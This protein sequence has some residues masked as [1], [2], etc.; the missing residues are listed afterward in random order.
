MAA[1]ANLQR[2]IAQAANAKIGRAAL[3]PI[4]PAA[5]SPPRNR[6]I[7]AA[8]TAAALDAT[9]EADRAAV[10]NAKVQ[11]QYAT[12][13]SPIAGRTGAL[14]VHEGNLVRAQDTSPLV[15]INQVA[16]IYVSFAVPGVAA[17][18]TEA[19]HLARH[20][21][22]RGEAAEREV[23]RRRTGTSRSWT[24][25]SIR[26]RAPSGSRPR[27]RTRIAGSGRASSSTSSSRSRRTRRRSSSRP[28]RCRS[29]SRASTRYVVKAGQLRRIPGR[30]RRADGRP[31][32]GDQERAQAGR[33]RRHGRPPAPGGRQ[34][35]QH[36][37][38]RVA[39]GAMNVSELFIKRPVTTTL[40]M[41][42]ILVFGTMAYRH[43]AGVGPAGRRLPDHPGAG[44]PAGRQPRNDGGDGGVA[45]REAV[46]GHCRPDQHQFDQPQGT[47]NITLQFDLSRNIDAAAQDVQ[48]MIGRT[49]RALPP[50]MP[51]PPS[52]QKSNPGDQSVIL[53]VLRSATLPLS[54]VDEYA[55]QTIAQRLSMVDGVA[56]VDVFGS[57]K[58]A[59]RIDLDP[60]ELASRSI[61]IDEVAD[62]VTNANSNVPTGT[63]YGDKT[64]VVQTNGQL[65]RAAGY[66]STIV[67]YRNGNPVRLDE[68]AHVFDGVEND[69]SAAWQAGERCVH[70]LDPQA[71]G[72]QRRRGGRSHQGAAARDAR[73]AA[74]RDVARHRNDRSM[75]IRDVG[76]RRQDHAA[77]H[78][79][80]RRPGH[81]PVP[82]E[83][84][85]DADSEPGAAGVARRHVH[86]DVPAR[87]QPRQPVADGADALGRLRRRRRDR[88]AREHRPAHGDGQAADAGGVRR[89]EGNRVHHS[90][91]DDLARGR[92]H[93]GAVHGRHRRAAAAR[94]RGHDQRGDSGLGLRVDQPDADA[95]QPVPASRRTRSGTAASTTRSSACSTRGCASTTGRCA[96]RCGI[97]P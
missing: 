65:M 66:G 79:L 73:A 80:P 2:D 88:D 6:S 71:A 1:Q 18:R 21:G 69:K 52:Y 47:T 7:R 64:F 10:E 40:I 24:T 74:G 53:L 89:I 62:A 44:G 87:L 81:L 42:G 4:S 96:S 49:A 35:G 48:A 54:M 86:G 75:T 5:A 57:Q 28:P 67:A 13:A 16:P 90:V 20:A 94:V 26:R 41:L 91:D 37:R 11:L 27:S 56:Q 31:G 17:A 30:G 23:R 60:R 32:Y 63:I 25:T 15:V 61:G 19:L 33:D 45:A 85:G 3:Q 43:A 9:V 50:Q 29:A 12:I 36:Q 58:Y 92:L 83:H 46:R 14:M 55:Q 34:P 8:P 78:G 95:V 77:R 97:A 84:L 76:A 70:D 39:G 59:V 93:P 22:R 72:H 68:V 38:G 51:A 82:A